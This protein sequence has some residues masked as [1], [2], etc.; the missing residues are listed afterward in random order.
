M[1]ILIILGPILF[2]I[3]I[4][5]LVTAPLDH[6][7]SDNLSKMN[8]VVSDWN[9]FNMADWLNI[10]DTVFVDT[11]AP[12]YTQ[13]YTLP[14]VKGGAREISDSAVDSYQ[15][16]KYQSDNLL[17]V[18]TSVQYTL[19]FYV[20][21]SNPNTSLETISVDPTYIIRDDQSTSDDTTCSDNGGTYDYGQQVCEYNY[22]LDEIC[23]KF[24][25]TGTTWSAETKPGSSYGCYY[26]TQ[27]GDWSVFHYKKV[28]NVN[29]FDPAYVLV[30]ARSSEDPFIH[31]QAITKGTNDFGLT[32]AQRAAAGLGLMIIGIIF[33]LPCFIFVGC[34]VYYYN[35]R[36]HRQ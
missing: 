12:G 1:I 29:V 36:K 10:T 11:N 34:T 26:H 21:P 4:S 7:R 22:I 9:S 31:A 35:Y 15:A 32:K 27:S 14:T 28:D 3:G 30:T 23:V 17:W 24:S 5:L 13:R 2:I 18:D 20:N 19:Y 6:T 8:A 16:V 33:M 25:K